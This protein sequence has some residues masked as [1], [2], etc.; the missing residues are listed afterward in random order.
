[1]DF[2]WPL[3]VG[4]PG[5]VLDHKRTYVTNDA[6]RDSLIVP[7]MR[8]SLGLRS[9]LCSPV[10]DIHGDVIAFFALHNKKDGDFRDSDVETV[11]G[12]AQVASIAIQNALAYYRLQKAEDDLRRLSARLINSQDEE[13]R[14]IAR[15]LHETTAQDLAALRMSI[16]RIKRTISRPSG[17]TQEAIDESLD[18]S[19]QVIAAVRTLS[20]VLHPPLLEE[21]GLQGAVAWYATGFSKRSGINVEVDLPDDVGRLPRE[22]ETTFFRI[23]QECLTNVHNHSGS[24]RAYIRIARCNGIATME[25]KDDGKGIPGW[26]NASLSSGAQIGVGIAGMRE[27]VKQFH[28]TLEVESAPGTGTTVRVT[29]P[30]TNADPVNKHA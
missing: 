11:E 7:A 15:E 22:Y 19:N 24:S 29:L 5:W 28:G 16:G 18:L 27:R 12:I 21:A 14:R 13:R 1:V 20:Y 23:M 30:I 6:A 26:S 10:L 4:I 9:V 8:E 25:V 2:T 3:G 17:T